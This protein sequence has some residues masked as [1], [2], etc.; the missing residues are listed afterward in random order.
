M[1]AMRAAA[2][3]IVLLLAPAQTVSA[4]QQ[5]IPQ[6]LKQAKSAYLMMTGVD[7]RLLD[8]FA[9]EV[10]AWKRFLLVDDLKKAEI[11]CTLSE[12]QLDAKGGAPPPT[13][14]VLTITEGLGGPTLW[15][16]KERSGVTTGAVANLVKRLK[17]KLDKP[18]RSARLLSY[19]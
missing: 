2:C 8:R 14:I 15:T 17:D 10:T 4:R 5:P 1:F 18:D 6:Q 7:P 12:E 11:V 9:K 19:Q 13:L 3:L 16:D